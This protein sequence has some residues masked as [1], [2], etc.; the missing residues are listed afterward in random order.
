MNKIDFCK[1]NIRIKL[2]ET[3][4]EL[5]Q[6]RRLRYE[7]L[8]LFHRDPKEVSFEET[9]DDWDK[10]C[11]H[12]IAI[13]VTTNQV[14]GCYRLIMR[15]HLPYTGG[16]V[17][18]SNFNIDDVKKLPK[19][20][21]EMGRAAVKE[22]YRDGFVIKMLFAGLFK[23]VDLMNVEVIFGFISIPEMPKDE[24]ENLLGYFYTMALT[25]P[26]VQPYAKEPSFDLN[27]IP[28]DQ[29]NVIEAKRRVPP[30]LKAYIAMGCKF[31]TT[32]SNKDKLLHTK[33]V[34]VILDMKNI[35]RR[36]IDFITR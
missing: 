12:L 21:L 33:D 24:F 19:E 3:Q 26:N 2:V 14:V 13:D 29:V 20:L 34:F 1:N 28:A 30:V 25:D 23:Y 10:D 31:A 11:D 4:E 15:K 17:L 6:A 22:G 35:N 18:E 5:D 27:V 8:V 16:F 9:C 36:Y 32:G 7:E